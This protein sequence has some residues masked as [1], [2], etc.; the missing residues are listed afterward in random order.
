MPPAETDLASML[1]GLRP[2][3][4]PGIYVY[5]V[6]PPGHSLTDLPAIGTYHEPEGVT[7]ILEEQAARERGLSPLFRA[8]W[9]TLGVSSDLQAIGLTAAVAGALA[10]AGIACNVVA[11]VHHDHLLVPADRGADALAVLNGLQGG[12]RS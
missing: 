11:A 3:L 9:I 7:V 2:V 8:A 6:L 4:H 1:R 10:A 5:C 12:A